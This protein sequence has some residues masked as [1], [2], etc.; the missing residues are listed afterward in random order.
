MSLAPPPSPEL[1]DWGGSPDLRSAN[2]SS[3]PTCLT[4]RRAVE[5]ARTAEAGVLLPQPPERKQVAPAAE[6][7]G[8]SLVFSNSPSK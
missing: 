7:L 3:L 8:G 1:F 5:T 4:S 6:V 2:R